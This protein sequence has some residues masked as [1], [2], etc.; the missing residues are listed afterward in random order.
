MTPTHRWGTLTDA[1]AVMAA[2]RLLSS[3]MYSDD[4]SDWPVHS[5]ILSFHHLHYHS[6][7]YDFRQHVM[8]AY[9]AKLR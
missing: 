1:F 7:Y 9:M 6:L 8:T 5:L 2:H 3:A 4:N